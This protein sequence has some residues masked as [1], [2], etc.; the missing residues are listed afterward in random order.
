M[1]R[2]FNKGTK[3]LMILGAVIHVVTWLGIIGGSLWLLRY[4]GII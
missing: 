1:M 4:F 3:R 2:E